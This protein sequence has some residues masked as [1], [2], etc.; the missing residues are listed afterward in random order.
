ME[1]YCWFSADFNWLLSECK[2]VITNITKQDVDAIEKSLNDEYREPCRQIEKILYSYDEYPESFSGV[3]KG[4]PFFEIRLNFQGETFME[5]EQLRAYE[6]E[7]LLGNVGGY[8]GMI[9]GVCLLQL[10]S[11]VHNVY[12]LFNRK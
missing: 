10:P 4:G 2:D 1:K 9:L 8:V 3:S 7:S 6:F 5:I 12:N 11:L